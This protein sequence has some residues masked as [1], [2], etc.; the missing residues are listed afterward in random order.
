[1]RFDPISDQPFAHDS[2][3][4]EDLQHESA[5][6]LHAASSADVAMKPTWMG[7]TGFDDALLCRWRAAEAWCGLKENTA[8]AQRSAADDVMVMPPLPP[9]VSVVPCT[10]FIASAEN[11]VF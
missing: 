5:A 6:S 1:M 10:K 9:N 4:E 2:G 11:L 3:P 8:K 7:D